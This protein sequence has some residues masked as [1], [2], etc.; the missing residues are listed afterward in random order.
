MYIPTVKTFKAEIKGCQL[1]L[2][3]IKDTISPSKDIKTKPGKKMR[4]RDS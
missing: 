3:R 2:S 4:E 1:S